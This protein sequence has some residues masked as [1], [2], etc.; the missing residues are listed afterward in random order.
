MLTRSLG[1]AVGLPMQI[2]INDATSPATVV[3][4]GRLDILGAEVIALP[5]A[6]LSGAKDS[7]V[8]DMAGVS[9]I[10]SMGLRHLVSAAKTVRR[11]GGSLVL[12]N[13]TVPVVEVIAASGLIDLLPIADA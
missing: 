2:V 8:I 3:L 7:I 5:L 11:R 6:A 9:F 4:T 1:F 12:R 13:P 10:A